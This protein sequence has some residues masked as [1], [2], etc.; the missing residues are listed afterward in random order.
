MGCSRAPRLSTLASL[1]SRAS[2]AVSS[3]QARA[4][5]TPRILFAAI[6][7]PLPD[8]P[9]TIPRLPGSGN[10]A[11]GRPHDIRRIV[12]P[13]RPAWPGRSPPLMPG[14]G[15]P[16]GETGLQLVAS[17]NRI[18]DI[19]ARRPVW[20]DPP[21]YAPRHGS[22]PP[23]WQVTGSREYPLELQGLD[24]QVFLE[25]VRPSSRPYPRLGET[26]E[27]RGHVPR[28]RR[29]PRPARPHAGKGYRMIL[30]H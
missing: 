30:S 8:P 20:P 6:C 18:R 21:N 10:G 9:M 27:R 11:A 3:L 15:K 24:L 2:R 16:L 17:V 29:S 1:C 25:S 4:A 13:G 5:R 22:M 19:R 12:R 7:S 28:N 26:A 23:G 14:G